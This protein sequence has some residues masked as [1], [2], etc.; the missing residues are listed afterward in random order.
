MGKWVVFCSRYSKYQAGQCNKCIYYY[1]NL[2]IYYCTKQKY[3]FKNYF[4]GILYL[5]FKVN[6]YFIANNLEKNKSKI[7]H[8]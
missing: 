1:V 3:C 7:F 8:A 5:I 2:M 6:N 4:C